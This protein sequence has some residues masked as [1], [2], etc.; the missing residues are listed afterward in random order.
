VTISAKVE[1]RRSNEKWRYTAVSIFDANTADMYSTV[2]H[3]T[4]LNLTLLIAVRTQQMQTSS[5]K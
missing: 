3:V 4:Q 2:M 5:N 1:S